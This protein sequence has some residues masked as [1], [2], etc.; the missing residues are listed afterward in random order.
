MT[1]LSQNNYG[2]GQEHSVAP[3]DV[4]NRMGKL[5]SL[6]NRKLYCLRVTCVVCQTE[7]IERA[8]NYVFRNGQWRPYEAPRIVR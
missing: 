6:D 1:A 2:A 3:L 7:T 4:I 8:P 5:I